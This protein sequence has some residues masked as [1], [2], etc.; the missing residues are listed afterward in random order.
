MS[1]PVWQDPSAT[2][3]EPGEYHAVLNPDSAATTVRRWWDGHSWSKPYH[4][5]YPQHLIDKAKSEKSEFR[6]FWQ[7]RD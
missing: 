1:T 4:S 3:P 6:P 7:L 2:P 5:D